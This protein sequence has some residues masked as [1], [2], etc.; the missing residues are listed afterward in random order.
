MSDAPDETS[1]LVLDYLP[2]GGDDRRR[3]DSGPLAQALDPDQFRLYELVLADGADV[4]IGDDVGLR[5]REDAVEEFR[6][7]EFDDLSRGAQAELEYVLDELLEDDPAR[8]V[9]VFNEA[10]PITLRLHQLNLLPGIGDKLR[11]DILDARERA[12][13]EDFADVE[14]R[15]SGLHDP[16]EVIRDR[17]LAEL[18][19]DDIKYALFR[20]GGPY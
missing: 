9:T 3:F 17:M 5:P 10:Q 15:V 11:D 7:I 8:F 6:E 19:G 2:H 20:D 1:A 4:S 14:E 12:P 16:Q 13:F 18:R